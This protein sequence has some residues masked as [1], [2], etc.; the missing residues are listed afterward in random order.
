MNITVLIA[1]DQALIRSDSMMARRP[2]RIS[3]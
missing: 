2:E 1:D 3:A